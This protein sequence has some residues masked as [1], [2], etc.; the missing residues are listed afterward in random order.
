M[1]TKCNGEDRNKRAPTLL[2]AAYLLDD[3][4]QPRHGDDG[5]PHRHER[6]EEVAELQDVIL[7]DAEDHDARLVTGMVE[8]TEERKRAGRAAA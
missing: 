3:G 2:Q 8:L 1:K 5:D 4:L 6:A 7:H